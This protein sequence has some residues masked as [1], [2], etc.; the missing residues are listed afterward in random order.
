MEEWSPYQHVGAPHLVGGLQS[1]R[2][3]FHL[4][5]LAAGRTRLEGS[6]WYRNHLFPQLYWNA[7]SDALIH[8]IHRRVLEHVKRRSEAAGVSP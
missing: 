7:W 8:R 6:T 5:P 3:E 1:E 4:V 2:G